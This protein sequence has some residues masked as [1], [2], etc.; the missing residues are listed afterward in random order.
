MACSGDVQGKSNMRSVLSSQEQFLKQ[1]SLLYAGCFL[2]SA[3]RNLF[4][5]FSMGENKGLIL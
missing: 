2:S 3:G 1:G 5:V 4:L